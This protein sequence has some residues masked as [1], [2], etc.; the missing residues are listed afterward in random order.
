VNDAM[1]KKRQY[2]IL[3]AATLIV[4]AYLLGTEV[5]ERWKTSV[6]LYGDLA[7]KQQATIDPA[8]LVAR[9]MALTER[10]QTLTKQIAARSQVFDQTQSGLMK[11]LNAQARSNG[12]R[13]ESLVPK[14]LRTSGRLKESSLVIDFQSTFQQVG[15][16]VNA[17][18]T[19]PFPLEIDRADLAIRQPGSSVLQ[20]RLEGRVAL[21]MSIGGR[22]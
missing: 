18:E 4:F 11:F 10:K 3:I 1:T 5:I 15:S 22:Q 13:F 8:E 16:F 9:K 21:P 12:F 2:Q 7:K 19:G 17:L 14:E 6:E 20:V